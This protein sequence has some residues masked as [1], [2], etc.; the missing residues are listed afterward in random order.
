MS[1][2][3]SRQARQPS[4]AWLRLSIPAWLPTFFGVLLLLLACLGLFLLFL[5]RDVPKSDRWGFWGFQ[6]LMAV[7][8]TLS[9]MLIVRRYPRHPIGW[10]LLGTGLFSALTGLSEEFALYTLYRRPGLRGLGI[11]VS[12]LFNWMWVLS[13]ALMAIFIPLFFPN[14]RLLTSRWRVVAWLG[15]IWV[16]AGSAWMILM[17]GSLPNNG[18]VE[19]PF[20][21]DILRSSLV[22]DYDPRVLIP[23]M[24]M[25]LMMAAALSL[26]LRYRRARDVTTRQ[27]IKWVMYAALLMPFA[28]MLGQL[29]GPVANGALV[30]SAAAM[31]AAF[32]LAVLRYR[33]YDIDLLIS[34]TVAYAVLTAFVLGVYALG[35]AVT[36]TLA[37]IQGNT[38]LALAMAVLAAVLFLPLRTRLQREVNRL[39]FGQ[40]DAPLEVLSQL[41]RRMESAVSPEDMLA[42]LVETVARALKLPYVAVVLDEQ[43]DATP[44]AEF[45]RP[46]PSPQT[47]PLVYRGKSAG[48]LL[49]AA[50]HPGEAFHEADL[51]LLESIARQAGAAAHAARLTADLQR[52]RRRLVEAREEERR[53]LRRDLHDDLGPRL[54]SMTLTIEAIA[55]LVERDTF[56]AMAMLYQLKEQIQVAVREIRRLVY[57]LRPPTL[58][59]LGLTASLRECAA[60]YALSGVHIT[61]EAPDPLPPLPA[62]VEVAAFRIA[63]EAMTNAVRHARA[64]ACRVTLCPEAD[65]LRV[66]V[67][68]D[69]RGLPQPLEPGVG[70]RSMQE[71]VDELGGRFSLEHRA[72]GGTVVQAWLPWEKGDRP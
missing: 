15:G 55:R 52:S 11:L 28:G 57:D 46:T 1:Q 60:R 38:T 59:D 36:S 51:A 54:A 68:D 2:T 39:L 4:I 8:G 45:G 27:Q 56:Q 12:G 25:F 62:A 72:S 14:G 50:R 35:V 6:S 70:L 32:V 26:V 67:E 64:S 69:G 23:L 33:L 19:N 9:G 29:S 66:T 10:M 49:V 37:Q 47:F 31:P 16:L 48:R 5:N 30:L 22:T 44:V 21:L 7:M 63:Q 18:D 58:D 71:R 24:G 20:G 43:E 13:Y 42:A 34:R 40:R 53:R 65:H 3:P 61:V 41:G 17:P